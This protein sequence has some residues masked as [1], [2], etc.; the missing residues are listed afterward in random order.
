[1]RIEVRVITKRFGDFAAL[2]DSC[3][4]CPKGSLTALLGP[5]G[6]GKS[7]LLRIIAGLET[8]T[9]ARFHRRQRCHPCPPPGPRDRL[10]LPTLR[11]VRPYDRRDNVG[12]GLKIRKRPKPEVFPHAVDEL[13]ELV[14][15][16]KW[17]GSS[18]Q[19]LSGGQRQRTAL[20]RAL[21]VEPEVL[22]LDELFGAR[23]D[24]APS[25][26][27]GCAGCTTSRARPPCSSPTIRRRRWRSPTGSR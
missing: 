15:L 19:Q 1:M 10:R 4:G 21:A 22:L 2:E 13:L 20:A 24:S 17:A 23:R 7:T 8:P 27:C 3:S 5:S 18:P 26:A 6:S 14:G 25:C 9:A 11:P 12:F 16:T